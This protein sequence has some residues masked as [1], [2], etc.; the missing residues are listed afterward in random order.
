MKLNVIFKNTKE[1][2][3]KM[4]LNSDDDIPLMKILKF[5]MLAIIVRPVFE[6]DSKLYTQFFL[7]KCL[8]EQ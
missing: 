1:D 4:K 2:C 7:D 6:E 8:H 5:H 3:M